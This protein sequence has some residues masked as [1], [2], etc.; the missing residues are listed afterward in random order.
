[1]DQIEAQKRSL[2]APWESR[3]GIIPINKWK[4]GVGK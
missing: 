3:A 4:D 2:S 1:M